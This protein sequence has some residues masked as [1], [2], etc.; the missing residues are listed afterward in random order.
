MRGF[1]RPPDL[2]S[3]ADAMARDGNDTREWVSFGTVDDSDFIEFD[4]EYG[5]L[6]VVNLQP[7]KR[8]VRCRIAGFVA[9]K[10]EGEFYPYSAGDEVIV[11]IPGGNV[12]EGCVILGRLNN[13]IDT[14]PSSSVAGQDPTTNKI[15]FRRTMNGFVT[16]SNGPMLFRNAATG[17]LFGLDA[18]G[19]VT[20]RDGEGAGMQFG[21]DFFGY[22]SAD[23][24][25]ILQLDTT[26]G[27]FTVQAK[28]ALL[29]LASSSVT[30]PNTSAL[31]V[32]GSFSVT[33]G[34]QPSAEHVLT[35]EAML[36]IMS[37]FFALIAPGV[38]PLTGTTL[39]AAWFGGLPG[40]GVPTWLAGAALPSAQAIYAPFG[41]TLQ[42]VLPTQQP[43]PPPVPG[44]GQPAP[45]FGCLSFLVG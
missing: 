42:A 44:I 13:S 29:T 5:P 16:E 26:E 6:V 10:G 38:V 45:G 34:A 24:K 19:S 25:C 39:A 40:V 36:N 18:S 23:A 28:D 37:T 11:A 30:V 20:L 31:A 43:K 21:A 41:A 22:Q 8:Q 15:G 32:P 14:F 1:G 12:R 3:L 33:T 7:S 9:G 17:A 4:D 27:R 2:V 35:V